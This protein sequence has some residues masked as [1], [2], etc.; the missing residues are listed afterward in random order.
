MK[1]EA[2]IENVEEALLARASDLHRVELCA[3]LNIGGITPSQ[4]LIEVCN[5]RVNIEIHTM[6]RPRGGDFCY[7]MDEISIMRRDIEMAARAG[8]SGVVFGTLNEMNQV[9]QSDLQR[10]TE[11]AKS[12]NM[13]VTFHRAFDWCEHPIQAL[14]TLIEY[15]VDRI[16]TTGGASTAIEG[17]EQIAQ[18]VQHANGRIQI[19]A[20]GGVNSENA[21]KLKE[22]GVDALHFSIG[23]YQ[24][25][26]APEMGAKRNLLRNKITGIQQAIR[27]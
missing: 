18:M 7:H 10:L 3:S 8:S 22:S 19:M 2:C 26:F 17:V 25:E 9:N 15:G 12:L 4:G 1:L 13:E 23:K 14:D 5:E 16:L 6:I 11:I 27:D 21:R 20:G 24:D